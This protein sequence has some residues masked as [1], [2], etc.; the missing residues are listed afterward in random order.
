MKAKISTLLFAGTL[1][2]APFAALAEQESGAVDLDTTRMYMQHQSGWMSPTHVAGTPW[3]ADRGVWREGYY[4]FDEGRD[5]AAAANG[6]NPSRSPAGVA[7][8]Q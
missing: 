2:A 6:M 8:T 7:N 1:A 3:A 4:Y 5:R